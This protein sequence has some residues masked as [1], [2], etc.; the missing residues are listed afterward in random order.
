MRDL[1]FNLIY[2]MC[3]YFISKIFLIIN[4]IPFK[5]GFSLFFI[6]ER[7]RKN[8]LFLIYC[9]NANTQRICFFKIFYTLW[10]Q[11][12]I[13]KARQFILMLFFVFIGIVDVLNHPLPPQDVHGHIYNLTIYNGF[14]GDCL[15]TIKIYE[16][17]RL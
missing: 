9:I 17:Y 12:C 7:N 10:M 5:K 13:K 14:L 3:I 15:Y 1:T 2:I 8:E 11:N 4:W 6:F 16:F